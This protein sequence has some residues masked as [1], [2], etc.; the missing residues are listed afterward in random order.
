MLVVVAAVVLLSSLGIFLAAAKWKNKLIHHDLPHRLPSNYQQEANGFTF[1]HAFGAHSQYK[2]HASKEVQL[3][4][5]RVL[6]HEVRIELFGEDGSRLDEI[7]GDTFEYDQKSQLAIAVGP[8]EMDLTQPANAVRAASG[9]NAAGN[10][11]PPR[12]I[13]VKTS[14]VTFDQDTGQVATAQR[15]DF[16]MTAG[17]GTSMGATYDSQNGHLTLDRAVELETDRGGHEVKIHAQHAEFDRGAQTCWLR[18]ATADER[19]DT[20]SAA[21]AT[22]LFRE[23][24]TAEKLDATGGFALATAAG[25]HVAAP[26]ATMDFDEHSQP[27][28]GHL[29]GGVTMDSLRNG[30]AANPGRMVHGTAPTAELEFAGQGEL[31]HAHM[32][33]GVEF[34]EKQATGNSDQGSEKPANG[35][36]EALN[37]LRT[38]HSPVADVEFRD[39]GKGQVEP[40]SLHGTGGVVVTSESRR[41]NE[42]MR[43]AKMSADDVTGSFGPNSTLQSMTG[44]GHAAMEQTTANGTRQTANGDR[45][46]ASFAPA[47][48]A[49][50]RDQAS[51]NRDQKVED[52]ESKGAREQAGAGSGAAAIETAELDGHVVLFEQPQAKSG[53]AQPPIRATAGKA[54]YEGTGEWLHLTGDSRNGPRVEN[55][56][57]EL[58]ADKVDVSQQSG[59]GF[60]HGNVKATWSGGAAG[61]APSRSAAAGGADPAQGAVAFGG[62]GPAHVISNE[63]EMNETTGEATF[64]GHARLWQQANSVAAPVIVLNQH[65]QTLTAHA[66]NAGEPVRA[67]LLSAGGAP[68]MSAGR[69]QGQTRDPSESSKPAT[70]S[71][72]RVR[73]GDLEYS[74]AEHRAVMHGGA[75]GVVTAETGEATSVSDELELRLMPAGANG[76]Q[77]QVDR[78]TAKGHVVLTSQGR[79]GTGELLVYSSVTGNYVLTGTAAAPPRMSDPTQ[80]NVT[81][82]A[83]IFHSRDDSVSIEGGGHETRTETTAPEAP[84]KH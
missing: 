59:D 52:R 74:D 23:D 29:E 83:L 42:A 41:E 31:R 7:A 44:V 1:T 65:L 2:I 80:G 72:I 33:R 63:A 61:G 10:T 6:L 12:Q 58:T 79:R 25:G 22:I 45:I 78:M 14:G 81:G 34:T 82:E 47:G 49:Q 35:E 20:M 60:A 37:I 21:Q 50:K 75:A 28:H 56:G 15:V 57:L 67:V 70:P 16:S 38:W 19:G 40:A 8:V 3:R 5:N 26:K 18:E 71:V 77:T 17:S 39:A 9:P 46:E 4:D 73:G 13:H 24:G 62:N 69:E 66:T 76:G 27:R 36:V 68:G 48:A 43:P 54:V 51:R 30:D 64:R 84:G 11:A 32:E 55:G 53:Q